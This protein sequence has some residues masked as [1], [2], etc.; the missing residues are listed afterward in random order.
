[1]AETQSC[2]VAANIALCN[3][4]FYIIAVI[5]TMFNMMTV[6]G[7]ISFVIEI[8][9]GRMTRRTNVFGKFHGDDNI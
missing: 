8:A 9:E 5:Y 4:I 7:V 1:M 3:L 6:F 2:L